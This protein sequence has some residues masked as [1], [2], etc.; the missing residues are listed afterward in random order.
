MY[1]EKLFPLDLKDG[2]TQ[3]IKGSTLF[4]YNDV[5]LYHKKTVK[6]MIS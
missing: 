5:N 4:F 1:E 3:R 6:E 2:E